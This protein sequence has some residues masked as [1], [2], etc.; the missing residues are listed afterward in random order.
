MWGLLISQRKISIRTFYHEL[1]TAKSLQSC[2]TLCDPMDRDTPP[3]PCGSPPDSSV[4][5]ILQARIQ[6]WVSM[7][8]SR[9]RTCISCFAGRF[10]THSATWEAHTAEKSSIRNPLGQAIFSLDFQMEKWDVMDPFPIHYKCLG[11]T[12]PF[13]LLVFICSCLMTVDLLSGQ[14]LISFTP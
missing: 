7:P 9:D 12:L 1:V 4:H 11:Y 10:F 2:L 5:G 8:S 3:Y 13:C 6:E 14:S